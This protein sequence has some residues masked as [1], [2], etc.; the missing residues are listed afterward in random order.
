VLIASQLGVP[1][2]RRMVVAGFSISAMQGLLGTVGRFVVLRAIIR[3]ATARDKDRAELAGLACAFFGVALAEG[4]CAVLSR[5]L[6][7]GHV[8]HSL[9]ARHNALLMRKVAKT[10]TQHQRSS[11]GEA[12][13]Q[14][15][16]TTTPKS[17]SSSSSARKSKKKKN[18]KPEDDSSSKAPT[19]MKPTILSTIY[20]SDLPRFL[21]FV[22]YLSMLA[23]GFVSLVGGLTIIAVFL[24]VAALASL[25]AILVVY[26]A[27]RY[28]TLRA[29]AAEPELF[30]ARDEV[31]AA[32]RQ[33]VKAMKAVKFYAWEDQF[34]ELVASKRATQSDALVRYRLPLLVSISIGKSFPVIATVVTLVSVAARRNGNLN[35]EDAFAA[36]A[37]FQTIRV[38][39]IILPISIV[40]VHTFVQINDRVAAYL[41]LPEDPETTSAAAASGGATPEKTK[42]DATSSPELAVVVVDKTTDD[43]EDARLDDV[44]KPE[45]PTTP[46]VVASVRSAVA[47]VDDRF[48]LR[49]DA[50][51][52]KAGEIVAVVGGVGAGKT[53]LCRLLLSR[54]APGDG[55][56]VVVR[57]PSVGFAPQDPIVVSGTLH[58]NITLGRHHAVGGVNDDDEAM[59]SAV[60]VACLDRD[61]ASTTQFPLGLETIVGERGTTLSGGQQARLQVARALFGS[62]A[63]VILDSSFAAVDAPVARAMF[64][65]LKR[66]VAAR[67]AAAVVV[68]SQLHLLREVD[69]CVVLDAGRVV[70]SGT[71]HAVLEADAGDSD[72]LAFCQREALE[73]TTT[74]TEAAA[75]AARSTEDGEALAESTTAAVAAEP[76][77]TTTAASSPAPA[78]TDGA[79]DAVKHVVVVVEP[80]PSASSKKD[81]VDAR[82]DRSFW[83]RKRSHRSFSKRA[84]ND[85]D[86][87]DAETTASSLQL[88]KK[89]RLRRGA[90]SAAVFRA[91]ARGVG[92]GKLARILAL[93]YFAALALFAS[94][95]V[96]ARWAQA[97]SHLYAFMAAYAGVAMSYLPVLVTGAVTGIFAA[98]AGANTLHAK[99]FD[100]VLRAP[101]RW[102]DSVPSGRIVSRFAADFDVLDLEWAQMLD[103]GVTMFSMWSMLIVAITIIVPVLLP[104][105]VALVYALVRMLGA[106]NVANRDVKRIANTAVA[107]CVTNAQEAE[108]ARVVARAAGASS[109]F[110]ERQRR[111]VDAELKAFFASTSVHQAAYLSATAL[112]SFMSLAASLVIT[113]APAAI[114]VPGGGLTRDAAPVALTYALVSPYFASLGSEVALQ[115]SLYATSLER[116]FEY[117]PDA[118]DGGGRVPREPPHSVP[119]ADA[120]LQDTAWPAHGAVAFEAVSLRYRPG[121]PLAL[122][123]ASFALKPGEKAGVV[124]R[125]GAGKST[126]LVATFR[127]VDACAGR[128]VIDGVDIATLGVTTLR[129][130]LSL[131]AQDAVLLAGDA[132]RNLDPFDEFGDAAAAAALDA[133]GLPRSYL[134]R[135]DLVSNDG[136]ASVLSTGQR[137]L[138]A[139]ARCLLRKSRVVC[140]DEATAHVDAA[141]DAKVQ[142]VI[143]RE[144]RDATLLAIAHR[145]HTVIAFDKILLMSDGHVAEF[146]APAALLARGPGHPFYD[147]C[148]ALGPAALD[149][150]AA[151]A[152]DASRLRTEAPPEEED[153]SSSS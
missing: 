89:E 58:E 86:D 118:T 48:S 35:A 129:R 12:S 114:A 106:I 136:D 18:G 113:L 73:T 3:G 45:E 140:L 112:C 150:L 51:D 131:I 64:D 49:V 87:E 39:M 127:L 50:L 42:D 21:G 8:T 80:P 123:D 120:A 76:E 124:G 82:M 141:T 15:T 40:L 63:L 37:V 88:V 38:G 126:I 13:A 47:A 54:L 110:V 115:L 96:L 77:T 125:T 102:F 62:P 121:L 134:H 59:R 109:F 67:G 5:Q 130:R 98:A 138:L 133:V 144:F 30:G 28:A 91:W 74:T 32:I 152:A 93:Y 85:D 92:Y 75:E 27:Q 122:R 66:W 16:K 52:I 4:L 153:A 103:G 69:P 60:R 135:G 71:P 22:R 57:A 72:F 151:R 6:L 139:L 78:A 99:T 79:A 55:G 65:R 7:A 20:A 29:N 111:Y 145:L 105:N 10:S 116:L 2:L 101:M 147:T 68:L 142:A 46:A 33:A 31:V 95:L 146:D 43:D 17:S 128:V 11:Q 97:T 24:G 81:D 34:A 149:D 100:S 53:S 94:D 1:A 143:A 41:V 84:A 56:A 19:T 44:P 9:I 148:A 90:V 23:C 26:A 25:G 117:L 14:K 132:K 107:P 108:A 61:L 36:L 137:Q 70:A 104:V 119:A 83:R